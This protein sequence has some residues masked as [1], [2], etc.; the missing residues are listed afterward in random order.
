[1]YCELAHWGEVL[2]QMEKLMKSESADE[3]DALSLVRPWP[4]AQGSAWFPTGSVIACPQGVPDLRTASL[5]LPG[6]SESMQWPGMAG[7]E[8]WQV[9][10]DPHAERREDA[11][12]LLLTA[13]RL[14]DDELIATARIHLQPES[15]GGGHPQY[16]AELSYRDDNLSAM[17][18]ELARQLCL[19][20]AQLWDGVPEELA[21]GEVR[22]VPTGI[23][24]DE[25]LPSSWHLNS[26]GAMFRLLET[27][28]LLGE[29]EELRARRAVLVC[30]ADLASVGTVDTPSVQ[31]GTAVW[32]ESNDLRFWPV[33]RVPELDP[34]VSREQLPKEILRLLPHLTGI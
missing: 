1:M 29:G 5:L 13:W 34:P 26:G 22:E 30:D 17:E 14:G 7:E 21:D 24:A 23:A 3:L 31:R 6:H 15:E 9:L 28:P 11:I 2:S 18:Q 20:C 10:L 33:G 27:T 16:E 12:P 32:T 25:W 4:V 8:T 19:G